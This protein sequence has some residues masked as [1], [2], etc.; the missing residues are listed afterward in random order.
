[1]TQDLQFDIADH[2]A[3]IR[4]NRPDRMNAFTFEM[5]AGIATDP[6]FGP[7]LMVGLGG[8]HV[9]I[10]RDVAST[11]LPVDQAIAEQLVDRLRGA[12]LL[13]PVRG[14]PARDRAALV[15]LLSRLSTLAAELSDHIAEIDLNPVIVH[16]TGITIV[17]ALI[18]P[19]TEDP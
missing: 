18:V 1:M 16:E 10:L 8:I 12:Q 5:I 19:R 3:T 7:L 14:A 15:T 17:D 4:L 2:I 11:P 6:D 13:G 9:E